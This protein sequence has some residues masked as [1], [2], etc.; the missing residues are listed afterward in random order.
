MTSQLNY[1]HFGRAQYDQNTKEWKFQRENG[2]QDVLVS[3]IELRDALPA[4]SSIPTADETER[5]DVARIVKRYPELQTAHDILKDYAEEA[6][7]S[8]SDLADEAS[9]ESLMS[10]GRLTYSHDYRQRASGKAIPAFAAPGGENGDALR[11]TRLQK[12][13]RRLDEDGR[14]VEVPAFSEEVGWW[15]GQADRIRQICFAQVSATQGSL[16]AI[17]LSAQIIVFRP[18]WH[19]L[20]V[21]PSGASYGCTFP[22][23]RIEAN[24]ILRISLQQTGG[25]PYV[26]MCFNPKDQRQLAVVDTRGLWAVFHISGRHSRIRLVYEAKI[27]KRGTTSKSNHGIVDDESVTSS[28]APNDP[29]GSDWYR[30]LWFQN[31]LIIASRN[32]LQLANLQHGGEMNDLLFQHGDILKAPLLDVRQS[33]LNADEVF[34]L[35]SRQLLLFNVQVASGR[36]DVAMAFSWNHFRDFDDLSLTLS[37]TSLVQGM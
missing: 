34:V 35:D 20:R 16:L 4:T 24:P 36:A 11:I 5:P 28:D 17:R 19:S 31:A 7:R 10:F 15:T 9:R 23:S 3:L 21:P 30:L 8:P 29:G 18:L 26:D 12:S 37:V 13:Q 27:M 25:S 6:L 14:I 1:G 2:T 22:P 32:Q 33:P